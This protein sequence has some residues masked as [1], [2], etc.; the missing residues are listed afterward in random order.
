VSS[1]RRTSVLVADDSALLR[2]L[3]GDIIA[4]SGEF[5]VAGF[6]A[7]GHDA[8]RLVHELQPDIVT[9][10]VEMPGLDGLHALGY[11]MS[12]APRPVIV[13]SALDATNGAALAIR[14]LELGALDFVRKPERLS[15]NAGIAE[16]LLDALRA[17]ATANLAGTRVLA[18][19]QILPATGA[20]PTTTANIA[21][22]IAASTGG[23]RAL[24]EVIP[25]LRED[26]DAAV[27]IVQH[28]PGGFTRGFA[29]RLDSLSRLWVREAK[30]GERLVSGTVYVAPGGL[31]LGLAAR[32]GG[33]SV[34]V[35]DG[36]PVWGVRPA[37]DPLFASVAT[38]FG[39]RSVGVVLTGMGRDGA[40]GLRAIR[41][42]GGRSIVQTPASAVVKGMPTAALSEGGAD[43]VVP[44]PDIA[45]AIASLV[46]RCHAQW[47]ASV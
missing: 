4:Q 9:M 32:Q 24:A 2:Q 7:D 20:P 40:Q 27:L 42:A 5:T 14:A 43:Q 23:P 6:A 39:P 36:P 21:V 13:L 25:A 11:I 41:R 34:T 35:H 33:P 1:E 37:A 38:L 3:V 22:A 47:R 12:E 29:E 16:P 31:H 17:A 28:M 30:D 46:A 10:D 19:P 8:V 26:L 15:D 45:G 18:R 44:L